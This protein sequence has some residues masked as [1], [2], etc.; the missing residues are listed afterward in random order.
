MEYEATQKLQKELSPGESLLWSGRPKQ[1]VLLRSTDGFLIPFSLLW[2]GSAVFATYR[3]YSSAA[4]TGG[5]MFATVFLLVGLYLIIGRFFVDSWIRQR[6]FYGVTGSR[7]LILT[8][9]PMRYFNTLD[10]GTLSDLELSAKADGIGT[11]TFGPRSTRF[12]WPDGLPWPNTRRYMP[13]RFELVD[14]AKIVYA[15]IRDARKNS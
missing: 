9:A 8:E 12:G 4:T 13:S 6:T 1:G 2:S 10:L 14:N 5:L 3:T 15:T 11:I 7:I